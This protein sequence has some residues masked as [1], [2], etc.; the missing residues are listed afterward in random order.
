MKKS[1]IASSIAALILAATL[2]MP[3]FASDLNPQPLPPG[4]HPLMISSY[5]DGF[6]GIS[7][8][9]G[10]C[11]HGGGGINLDTAH[12]SPGRNE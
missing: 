11:G 9:A 12:K 8:C 2:V 1:V 3:A 10:S 7:G 4:R 6:D 5:S